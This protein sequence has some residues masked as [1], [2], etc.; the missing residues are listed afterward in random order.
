M[1]LA[2]LICAYAKPIVVATGIGSGIVLGKYFL[3]AQ[4]QDVRT[5]PEIQ[6][7]NLRLD[8]EIIKLEYENKE[9]MEK[10]TLRHQEKNQML[11][12][13]EDQLLRM[14]EVQRKSPK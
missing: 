6:R 4:Q 14:K 2:V 5:L 7:E 8:K 12:D 10:V 13:L 1:E 11:N 3:Q 9:Y